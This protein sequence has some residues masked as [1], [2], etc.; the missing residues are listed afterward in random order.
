[1]KVAL[2]TFRYDAHGGAVQVVKTLAA[3][4]AGLGHEVVVVT[5][6]RERGLEVRHDGPV[7]VYR[8]RPRNLYWVG[9][10]EEQPRWKR[11]LWQLADTSN[12]HALRVVRGILA[13]ETPDL[14]HVHKLRGLSPSVWRAAPEGGQIPV[15]HT[16][17]DYELFSPEGYLAGPVGRW[18]A[19]GALPLRPYESWRRRMSRQVA[20]ATAPSRYALDQHTR[21]GFFPAA[22][23]RVVPN[24]HGLTE[25]ELERRRRAAEA[26]GPTGSPRRG[27]RL[28]FLG[29]L[30]RAKGV[31]LLCASFRRVAA[32][33]R[34]LELWIAGWGSLEGELRARHRD[35][36]GIRFLGPLLGRDKERA[37]AACD[38]VAVPSVFPEIFGIVIAEAFASGKPVL[39][40]RAGG[41]PE[42]VE[43]DHTG[44][45][46]PPGDRDALEEAI[47]KLAD[48]RKRLAE[49]AP[50][51]FAKAADFTVE[52]VTRG[53]LDLYR[54]ATQCG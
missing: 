28:L 12:P 32:R 21:R 5:T 48:D 1:M 36:A 2:V 22:T 10:K 30:E 6:R 35:D 3:A 8:F 33:R 51:C 7:R 16:C 15:I 19:R 27:L 14:V 42:L 54:Q 50:A 46:V 43:E 25:G 39:A 40:T 53:Y 20:A 41:I 31:D 38:I 9:D 47:E 34:S 44:F 11:A 4:L 17:H 52:R 26:G 13:A 23:H 29:R 45:L 18:A 49:M 24:S 37:L